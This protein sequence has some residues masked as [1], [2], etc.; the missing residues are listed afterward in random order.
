LFH[1]FEIREI[2][3]VS[4]NISVRFGKKKTSQCS[5]PMRRFVAAPTHR[6]DGGVHPVVSGQGILHHEWNVAKQDVSLYR[7]QG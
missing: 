6:R 7:A 3:N 2:Q 5:V 4:F 1:I